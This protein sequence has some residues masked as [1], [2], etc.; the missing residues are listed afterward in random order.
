MGHCI[1]CDKD[2]F[3]IDKHI[4]TYH[5]PKLEEPKSNRGGSGDFKCPLCNIYVK[6][7]QRHSTGAL[8]RANVL[9]DA[10]YLHY[11]LNE[12]KIHFDK[13]CNDQTVATLRSK[14]LEM[15]DPFWS[16]AKKELS[17]EG[18]IKLKEYAN[19]DDKRFKRYK[20]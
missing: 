11:G 3:N 8:H 18:Y 2:F 7:R 14:K 20:R 9:K 4:D 5:F 6:N 10:V 12:Y 1:I 15:E 13:Y 17:N 19:G 16:A